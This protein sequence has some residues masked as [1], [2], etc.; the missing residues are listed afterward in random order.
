MQAYRIYYQQS[1]ERLVTQTDQPSPEEVSGTPKRRREVTHSCVYRVVWA[2]KFNRPVLDGLEGEV[3]ALLRMAAS[4]L[5]ATIVHLDVNVSR[6][7]MLIRI[8]PVT[9]LHRT[10]RGLKA[11]TSAV[12]RA[13]HQSL[14][15]RIPTLWN[16][17]YLACSVGEEPA[18][19]EVES[20][21]RRQ[22][23]V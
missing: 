20:F 2:A 1:I 21:I 14:R 16:S 22:A 19:D 5:V 8:D 18:T 3:D 17:H 13:K 15:S 9:G 23:R 11:K 7:S 10:V 4:E 12:L 6:V